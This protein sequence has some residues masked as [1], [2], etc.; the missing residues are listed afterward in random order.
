MKLPF[1]KILLE[2]TTIERDFIKTFF[3][4]FNIGDEL[5]FHIKDTKVSKYLNIKI[6]TL[7][8]RLNNSYSKNEN[9][10]EK[11]D[12]IKIKSTKYN[13]SV[14]YML[15]YP[16]FERL[17]MNS[18]S[19][20]SENVRIYFSELRRFIFDNQSIIYQSM[21][22]KDDLKKLTGYEV[23]YFFAIDE[24]Y[25]DL[26]K[27]GRSINILQRLRNYNIGRINEVDLKFLCVVKN[28]VLIE[29]CIKHK[30]ID[31][32]T[33]KKKEI[34]KIEPK[35]LKKIIYKCYCNNISKKEHDNLFEELGDLLKFYKYIKNK[36]EI[37]PYIIINK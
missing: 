16:C 8:K 21:I 11:I 19:D 36:N 34:Y 2:Y 5:E 12:Y 18:H 13:S 9:Y 32:I 28:N 23:I 22:N 37:K 35:K 15:N 14:I 33:F 4:K 26:Y 6:R 10:M 29:N 25:K 17:A 3:K 24:K 27:I 20:N 31:N 30:L 1:Y 7:R